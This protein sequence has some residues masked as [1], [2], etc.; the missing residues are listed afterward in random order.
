M[1]DFLAELREPKIPTVCEEF[2]NEGFVAELRTRR[3]SFKGSHPMEMNLSGCNDN[4]MF[5]SDEHVQGLLSSSQFSTKQTAQLI[6]SSTLTLIKKLLY[7]HRIARIEGQIRIDLD[8]EQQSPVFIN[9]DHLEEQ[10]TVIPTTIKSSPLKDVTDEFNVQVRRDGRDCAIRE[11]HISDFTPLKFADQPYLTLRRGSDADSGYGGKSGDEAEATGHSTVNQMGM[12]TSSLVSSEER[13]CSSV[14]SVCSML[15]SDLRYQREPSCE[16]ATVPAFSPLSDSWEELDEESSVLVIDESYDPEAQKEPPSTVPEKNGPQESDANQKSSSTEVDSESTLSTQQKDDHD[17]CYADSQRWSSSLP[18]DLS[19]DSEDPRG[20][21]TSRV[22]CNSVNSQGL[23]CRLCHATVES[24]LEMSDHAAQTHGLFACVHCFQSFTTKHH[25]EIHM[26]VQS[27]EFVEKGT[28]P[29]E[30]MEV[31]VPEACSPNQEEEHVLDL[32]MKK[33]S[34]KGSKERACHDAD[35]TR[36]LSTRSGQDVSRDGYG[37]PGPDSSHTSISSKSDAHT[38]QPVREMLRLQNFDGMTN[39]LVS[40]KIEPDCETR[41]SPPPLLSLS[42]S[43]DPNLF[44]CKTED[45]LD[46]PR[47]KDPTHPMEIMH[48][49]HFDNVAYTPQRKPAIRFSPYSRERLTE[50]TAK[51]IASRKAASSTGT[52]Q[53]MQHTPPVQGMAKV[54]DKISCEASMSETALK[55][56][57]N[58]FVKNG[59]HQAQAEANLNSCNANATHSHVRCTS[60]H[61]RGRPASSGSYTCGHEGCG[62]EFASFQALERHSVD[63]HG[64]YLC[65]HCGKTFTARPNRDRHVRYHTGEKPYKCDLCPM[66]FHRGDDLKYHRT[67]RH[68]SAEPFVCKRC[69][70]TFTWNRD[71]ERHQRHCRC[72][73]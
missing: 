62:E 73:A 18:V 54:D 12:E 61:E 6:Q 21:L 7:G 53:K 40:I 59:G 3:F 34:G 4:H 31:Q 71:L 72:K 38:N 46:R 48:R 28:Y 55:N 66:A 43:P 39:G 8:D 30:H 19:G 15:G 58:A 36:A 49:E 69:N 57:V 27:R 26:C 2:D 11:K 22:I 60:S 70:R 42:G 44:E 68:P 32:S 52:P 10:S 37:Q 24:P 51:F 35:L 20:C 41:P 67:T 16:K 23:E 47:I 9:F 56:R 63:N 17:A 33:K 45:V 13:C 5:P 29:T 1:A 64:R 50:L 25:L 65:E 14:G